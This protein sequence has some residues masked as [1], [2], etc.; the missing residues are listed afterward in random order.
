MKDEFQCKQCFTML[1]KVYGEERPKP[2]RVSYD[3]PAC[4]KHL[5]SERTVETI[6]IKLNEK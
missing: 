3:C 2:K 6:K 4:S 1:M 5:Y